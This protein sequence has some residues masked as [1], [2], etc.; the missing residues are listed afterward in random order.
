MYDAENGSSD[1][2]KCFVEQ[3]KKFHFQARH[4]VNSAPTRAP[5]LL[6]KTPDNVVY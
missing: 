1:V 6:N 2:W 5:P 3:N 4:S